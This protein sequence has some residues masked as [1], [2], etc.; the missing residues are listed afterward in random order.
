MSHSGLRKDDEAL[1]GSDT[2][3]V[4]GTRNLVASVLATAFCYTFCH[5]ITFRIRRRVRIPG[6]PPVHDSLTSLSSLLV[7]SI[8]AAIE[9]NRSVAA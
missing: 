6:K 5:T 2:V 7:A 3:S 9:A 1:S 4:K 8:V